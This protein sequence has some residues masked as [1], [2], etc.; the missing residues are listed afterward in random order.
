M[1]FISQFIRRLL[2]LNTTKS[3]L[4]SILT[5]SNQSLIGFNQT[6]IGFNGSI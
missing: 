3:A 6:L 5:A 1:K 2:P 4:I